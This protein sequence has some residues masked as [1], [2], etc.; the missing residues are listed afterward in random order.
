MYRIAAI[1][2]FVGATLITAGNAS[3]QINVVEANVPF[4]FTV[5]NTVLPAGNYNFGF[6]LLHRDLLVIRDRAK[7]VK[8]KAFGQHGSIG[9]GKPQTLIFHHYGSQY[10]LSEIRFDSGSNGMFLPATKSEKQARKVN[11][12][13]GLVSAGGAFPQGPGNPSVQLSGKSAF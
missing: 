11:R 8:A 10:F 9:P 12:D 13:E 7:N 2:F 1:A 3:A 6:D 4:N 5:N